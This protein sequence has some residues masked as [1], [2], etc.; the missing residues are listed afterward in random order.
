MD[1]NIVF[2]LGA[3]HKRRRPIF[4]ILWPPS[5]HLSCS[6]E[7]LSL[8]KNTFSKIQRIFDIENWP[9]GTNLKNATPSWPFTSKL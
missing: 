8:R 2:Y 5:L 6:P 7:M 1:G 3:L 9:L 4:P